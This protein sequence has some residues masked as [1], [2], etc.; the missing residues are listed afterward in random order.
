MN[1]RTSNA[2]Q[3]KF[4]HING[5]IRSRKSKD[6]YYNGQKKMNNR[7]SNAL[8]EKFEHTN[9]IIRSRKSKKARQYNDQQKKDKQ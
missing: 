1:N 6:R 2:L 7:T 5:I 8:Q 9:G 4:K 3:E